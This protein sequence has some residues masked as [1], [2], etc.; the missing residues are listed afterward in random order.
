MQ[1]DLIKIQIRC[2]V[3]QQKNIF[4][5]THNTAL[6]YNTLNII[7]RKINVIVPIISPGSEFILILA[8]IL[9]I[10]FVAVLI[11]AVL[12]RRQRN[13]RIVKQM[14]ERRLQ[15][16]VVILTEMTVLC[17][18]MCVCVYMWGHSHNKI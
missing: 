2:I 4:L 9:P 16:D 18:S 8:I 13:R 17:V 6:Q 3:I 10:A 5:K 15:L 12:L 1:C 11:A 7:Y 14:E